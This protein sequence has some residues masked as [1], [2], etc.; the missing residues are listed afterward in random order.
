MQDKSGRRGPA[1][2]NTRDSSTYRPKDD[3][4]PTFRKKYSSDKSREDK[5]SFAKSDSPKKSFSPKPGPQ[6]NSSGKKYGSKER[7]YSKPS[8]GANDSKSDSDFPKRG[9]SFNKSRS[10]GGFSK[11]GFS[12]GKPGPMFRKTDGFVK[13]ES[14]SDK[15]DS[16]G[17]SDFKRQDPSADRPGRKFVK[18]DKYGKPVSYKK[19]A[20]AR[21]KRPKSGSSDE[22]GIRLNK[23]LANAGV[24]SRR[25]ADELI[26][27]GV[28]KVNGEIVTEMGLRVQPGDTVHFGDR[29][30]SGEPMV[31]VLMNKPKDYLTTTKDPRNRKTVMELVKNITTYRVFPVGRLDRMT[32]GVL[33][34]TND[35]DLADRLM[36]PSSQVEKLYHVELDQKFASVDMDTIRRGLTLEDG[37]ITPDEIEWVT[38]M[39]KKHVGIKLHSGRNRIVRRMFE[40]LGYKVMR[41]DRVVFAGL[42]K[43]GLTRGAS[44][45]LTDAEVRELKKLG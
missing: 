10:G 14:G 41:L 29:K 23:F 7:S 33:M 34:F 8:F 5:P 6:T 11:P 21:P 12:S 43:K 25:E 22:K 36:H 32:T 1:Q 26:A 17:E 28:V 13:R 15:P 38:G 19:A 31:Y 24:C 39:D 44:R 37:P 42:T 45:H 16:S 20:G 27:T 3:S 40:H 35:G 18:K 2:R 9:N 30:V 4:K